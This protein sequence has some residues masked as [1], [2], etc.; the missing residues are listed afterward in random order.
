M[1]N[2]TIT[3]G[4]LLI[5]FYAGAKILDLD[6]ENENFKSSN[7]ENI[8]VDS[9]SQ[10]INL[11]VQEINI[12]EWNTKEGISYIQVPGANLGVMSFQVLDDIRI[13]FL[14]NSSNEIVIIN[15]NDYQL[16]TRFSVISASRDFIYDKG[17]FYVLEVG[18]VVV[19]DEEGIV[20]SVVSF[21]DKFSGNREDFSI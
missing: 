16:S 6:I 10:K 17:L 7:N 5:V 13:A 12:T 1:K 15:R 4:V 21:P 20:K 9:I 18:K 14:S 8:L 2:A 11:N 19:Y 3:L